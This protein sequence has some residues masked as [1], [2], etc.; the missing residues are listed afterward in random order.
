MNTDQEPQELLYWF[1]DK[2]IDFD[3]VARENKGYYFCVKMPF[4]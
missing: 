3:V 4:I 1:S 2:L